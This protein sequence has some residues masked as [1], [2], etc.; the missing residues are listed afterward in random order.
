MAKTYE[1]I[2][3]TTVSGTSTA[4]VTFSSI[5][6]TY[7]DLVLV[8][9]TVRSVGQVIAFQLNGDTAANY[10][11]TLI[12]GTGTA[13][14]SSSS[15]NANNGQ[16]DYTGNTS[17][18]STAIQHFQNYANTTTYKTSLSRLSAASDFVGCYVNL[19][20]STAA[21]TSIKYYLTSGYFVAGSTFTLYGIKSF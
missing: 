21:I 1:P 9:N 7:T 16:V 18:P 6:G 2:A 20:R 12:Y 4:N 15:P 5:V 11:S 3:T 10:S 19:W 13:A 14:A 17:N 8:S